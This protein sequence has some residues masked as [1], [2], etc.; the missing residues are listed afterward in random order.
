MVEVSREWLGNEL[1][2]KNL[3]IWS[4][5]RDQ[6]DTF[7]C[8]NPLKQKNS[9]K[10]LSS[11]LRGRTKTVGSVS[12]C[13]GCRNLEGVVVWQQAG[14]QAR[15]IAAREVVTGGDKA[16]EATRVLGFRASSYIAVEPD[17]GRTS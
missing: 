6:T 14:H 5:I 8:P 7:R 17:S 4:A 13:S 2:R 16:P 12:Y 1:V 11:N 3:R 9:R 10:T 15:D